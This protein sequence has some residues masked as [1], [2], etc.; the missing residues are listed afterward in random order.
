MIAPQSYGTDVHS[1]CAADLEMCALRQGLKANLP[2]LAQR[3]CKFSQPSWMDF[4]TSKLLR[5]VAVKMQI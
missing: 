1:S 2:L 4:V 3:C 5:N